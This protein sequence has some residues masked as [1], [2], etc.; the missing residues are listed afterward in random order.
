[1]PKYADPSAACRKSGTIIFAAPLSLGRARHYGASIGPT[2]ATPLPFFEP[3][4]HADA[5]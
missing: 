4:M 1:M 2:P 5:R 3:P